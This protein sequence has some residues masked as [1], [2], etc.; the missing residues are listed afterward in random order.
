MTDMQDLLWAVRQGDKREAFRLLMQTAFR[1][2]PG[3]KDD[4]AFDLLVA[5][6]A[7]S[8]GTL[9]R[10]L[11]GIAETRQEHGNP[12]PVPV[13]EETLLRSL[14]DFGQRRGRA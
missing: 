8:H 13:V 6:L 4:L 2:E 7:Y 10:T 11:L 12:V 1:T 9:N 3:Y 5:T 14:R